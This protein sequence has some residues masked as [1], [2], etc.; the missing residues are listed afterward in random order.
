MR[1]DLTDVSL[2]ML[3]GPHG[4][5]V[6][7]VVV[8]DRIVVRLVLVGAG[9]ERDRHFKAAWRVGPPLSG[10]PSVIDGFAIPCRE[11]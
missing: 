10:P 4:V 11:R 8:A 2:R 9:R 1:G 6:P 5:I 7:G 3:V